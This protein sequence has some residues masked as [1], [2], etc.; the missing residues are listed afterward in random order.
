VV[1]LV[2]LVGVGVF[3]ARKIQRDPEIK[4]LLPEGGA[5]WIRLRLDE[6]PKVRGLES[7]TAA[8]RTRFEV[9][10]VPKQAFLEVRAFRYA[11]VF[12][13]GKSINA[14]HEDPEDWKR[15]FA[16]DLAPHLVP[17]KHEL[18]LSV[19]NSKGPPAVLAHCAALGIRTGRGWE[20][21]DH[22]REGWVPAVLADDPQT[23]TIGGEL[24]RADRVLLGLAPLLAPLF[25]VVFAWSFALGGAD[26]GP[27]WLRRATPSASAVRWLVL[28]AWAVLAA[29]NVAKLPYGVGYDVDGHLQYV[30]YIIRKG[31]I[32]LANQGWQMFQTPFYHLVNVPL[33]VVFTRIFGPIEVTHALRVVPILCAALQI[34]LCYRMLAKLHPEREDLQILGTLLGGLLPIGLYM[35]QNLANEPLMALLASFVLLLCFSLLREPARRWGPQGFV[36][37]GLLWGLAVLTKVTALLM[38]PMLVLLVGYAAWLHI[39]P[40]QRALRSAALRIG[41]V[42][43]VASLVCGWYF[44]RNWL[45]LGAPFVGGWDESRGY[46]W[47]Q[48]PGYRTI[49]QFVSFGPALFHPVYS[50]V[51]GFWDGFYSTLWLDGY[52]GSMVEL[53]FS[54]AWNLDWLLAG[55]W[56]GLLPTAALFAGAAVILAA[57]RR[58]ARSGELFALLWLATLVLAMLQLALWLSSFS[59][60]KAS[61]T[62]GGL[63]A[64]AAIG[65]RGFEILARHRLVR[66]FV[67]GGMACWALT[68]YAAYFVV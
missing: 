4:L 18:V 12:L 61:Y 34:E 43:G 45:V 36:L 66:A 39:S 53:D 15:R 29:N 49:R 14:S 47:W 5:E 17:G 25:V 33:Y 38:L 21:T 16:F 65:T 11:V 54:P 24:P 37:L 6:G 8:F 52:M 58:F 41:V 60:V 31:G 63:L 26:A 62:L 35:S 57:P 42:L 13:D 50:A 7:F 19:L 10:S 22:D 64:Y 3:A 46:I 40:P 1:G 59:T 55:T 48:E 23:N 30:L 51:Q 9:A 68:V 32:P 67:C 2:V 56:L 27:P 20:A 28:A 44:V